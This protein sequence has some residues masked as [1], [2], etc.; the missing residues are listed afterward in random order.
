MKWDII[1]RVLM[2]AGVFYL[3]ALI[4]SSIKP[5]WNAAPFRK[6]S[7]EVTVLAGS[8]NVQ[9]RI[10]GAC[11]APALLRPLMGSAK[12]VRV[13]TVDSAGNTLSV[14]ELNCETYI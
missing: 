4:P 3:V 9:S 10:Q 6:P 1:R 12:T 13:I 14:R 8:S 7:S 2:V 11:R 5:S